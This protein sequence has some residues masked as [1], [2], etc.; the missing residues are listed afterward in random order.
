MI[1][2]I[3]KTRKNFLLIQFLVILFLQLWIQ[4]P[5]YKGSSELLR[6]IS[7]WCILSYAY[8][9]YKELKN[10]PD[11]HPLLIL[12]LVTIQFVGFNGWMLA[13]SM[14]EGEDIK[15]GI[16]PVNDY[17]TEGAYFLLIEHFLVFFAFFIVD[18]YANKKDERYKRSIVS[19]VQNSS[20]NYFIIAVI[21]YLT[22]WIFRLLDELYPLASISSVLAGFTR[23]GQILPLT[24]LLFEKIKNPSNRIVLLIH[25][26]I[27]IVEIMLVLGIGMKEDILINLLP[28]CLYL[29]LKFRS[30]NKIAKFSALF[31]AI[32]LFVFSVFVV[33]PYISIFRSMASERKVTWNQIKTEEVVDEYFNYI[34]DINNYD[35]DEDTNRTTDYMMSRAGS[36]V[37]NAWAIHQTKEHGPNLDFFEYA[38]SAMIPRFM[39]PDKPP[40]RIGA[41]VKSLSVGGSFAYDQDEIGSVTLG[42]IGSCCFGLG[43]EAGFLIPLFVGFLFGLLWFYIKPNMAIGVFSLWVFFFLVKMILKDMESIQDCGVTFTVFGIIYLICLKLLYRNQKL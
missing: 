6:Y 41:I 18:Y 19:Q 23:M 30:G 32:C 8:L 27:V 24:F 12:E 17:I 20:R 43:L 3:Y 36:I 4:D 38:V 42:F 14:E 10:A 5:I 7:G 29:F 25:W 39:W 1:Q 2:T 31:M 21:T 37:C 33:F 40:V 9:L 16:Y 13:N 35:G 28:Y 11:F 26:L 22:V 34:Q 15:F